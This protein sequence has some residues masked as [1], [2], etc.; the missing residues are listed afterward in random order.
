MQRLLL[1]RHGTKE[2]V[3]HDPGLTE[4]GWQQ[5]RATA[6][7]LKEKYD[8]NRL[9]SSPLRRAQETASTIA[10]LTSLP[11]E[12]TPLLRE[13]FNWGDEPNQPREEFIDDWIRATLDRDWAPSYGDSSSIAGR[14]IERLVSQIFDDATD[15]TIVGV[16]HGGVI[17]DFV[18]NLFSDAEVEQV[19]PGY[20]NQY[21]LVVAEASVTELTKQANQPW[22]LVRFAFVPN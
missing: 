19:F 17:T 7:W 20:S 16:S 12:T 13:R 3:P 22:Q 15:Q 9:F 8:I 1:V 6:G 5:A 2:A 21:E 11:I 10:Q 4:Y 18:R 14:R